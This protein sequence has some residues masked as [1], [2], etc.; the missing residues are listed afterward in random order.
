MFSGIIQS[1]G[2]V[3]KIVRSDEKAEM[4]IRTEPDIKSFEFFHH[5]PDSIGVL[6]MYFMRSHH[7]LISS[8]G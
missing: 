1:L 8:E 4:T 3:E 6:L 5:A 7:I 2:T